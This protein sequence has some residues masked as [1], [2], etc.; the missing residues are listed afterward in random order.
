MCVCAKWRLAAS[1]DGEADRVAPPRTPLQ[2]QLAERLRS[3]E[4]RHGGV[5]HPDK[6]RRCVLQDQ[7][8]R[9]LQ[10]LERPA[11]GHHALP[12]HIRRLSGHRHFLLLVMQQLQLSVTSCQLNHF[13]NNHACKLVLDCVCVFFFF[14][15]PQAHQFFIII[16]TMRGG[17][18]GGGEL[19]Q[20]T[21]QDRFPVQW[22]RVQFQLRL[23]QGASF[24]FRWLIESYKDFVLPNTGLQK[25]I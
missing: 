19:C 10:E 18:W 4:Q 24:T 21:E 14:P 25:S 11:T 16:V 6:R 3:A 22:G 9:T 13:G 17:T 20:T 8:L 2:V 15:P 12:G 1:N 23:S 7:T 5:A